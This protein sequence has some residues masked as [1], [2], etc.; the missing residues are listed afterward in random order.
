MRF[1]SGLD[2]DRVY[3]NGQPAR[4]NDALRVTEFL[5]EIRMRSG[6]VR[7][8]QVFSQNNFPTSAGIAS[9]AS[10]FAALATAA[11]HATGLNYKADQLSD[12]ARLG[13]GSA[14]RSIYGGFVELPA[15]GSGHAS[16][17]ATLIENQHH[18]DISVLIAITSETPKRISSRQAMALTKHR[19]PYYGAWIESCRRELGRMRL[20]IR[21]RDLETVGTM[22]EH[23]ALK[24]HGMLMASQPGILYWNPGTVDVIGEV[25]RMRDEGH[26]AYFT[27][28]AGPQVK[29]ICL[30]SNSAKVKNR[31]L[32]L[33]SVAKV[34]ESGPGPPARVLEV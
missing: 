4:P 1:E 29:V 15:G 30:R 6:V 2:S 10:G 34:I 19:S 18:W 11:A 12:L 9:S 25:I 32:K 16:H 5:D 26:E 17:A 28:D 3:L 14:A 8:A 20:A 13:S 31:L 7:H 33:T 23:S 27:I 21:H 22:A 24:L